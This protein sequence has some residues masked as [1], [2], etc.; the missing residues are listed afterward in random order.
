MHL[1]T[2]AS[3]MGTFCGLE[4]VSVLQAVS[5]TKPAFGCKLGLPSQSDLLH[6][7]C[8]VEM[9]SRCGVRNWLAWRS[10]DLPLIMWKNIKPRAEGGAAQCEPSA[11]GVKQSSPAPAKLLSGCKLPAPQPLHKAT[12]LLL[13]AQGTGGAAGCRPLRTARRE[14]RGSLRAGMLAC[15][16][17]SARA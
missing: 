11:A 16:N 2:A 8:L 15:C 17:S 13:T 14:L 1:L 12:V 5:V 3:Y 10:S 6:T 9:F 4:L 7:G